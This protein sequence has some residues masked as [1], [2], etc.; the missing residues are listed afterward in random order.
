MMVVYF[1]ADL[2]FWY[3]RTKDQE[4]CLNGR[5]TVSDDSDL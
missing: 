2:I 1:F 4:G 5:Y 3:Y